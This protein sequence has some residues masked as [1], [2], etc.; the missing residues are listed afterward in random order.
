MGRPGDLE[1]K[2]REPRG[3]EGVQGWDASLSGPFHRPQRETDKGFAL[4]RMRPTEKKSS[5]HVGTF[6]FVKEP[7]QIYSF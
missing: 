6:H 7:F 4:L 3:V 1:A 5:H 2:K